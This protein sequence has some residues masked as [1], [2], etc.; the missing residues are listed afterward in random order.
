MVDLHQKALDTVSKEK[1]DFADLIASVIQTKQFIV[2]MTSVIVVWIVFN[3]LAVMLQFDPYPFVF[4]E[5]YVRLHG[6]IYRSFCH[7]ESIKTRREGP[8]AC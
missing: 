3:V 2:C 7:D 1:K 4:L 8:Q 6:R 5:P